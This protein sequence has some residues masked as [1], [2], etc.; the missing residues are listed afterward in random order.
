MT[1]Q[2]EVDS[3]SDA[4]SL[5]PCTQLFPAQDE[6]FYTQ[7]APYRLKKPQH[8]LD[9]EGWYGHGNGTLFQYTM[10]AL[11]AVCEAVVWAITRLKNLKQSKRL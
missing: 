8:Y 6:Y 2:A 7:I 10:A 4:L 1:T 5:I 3:L 9:P 11:S